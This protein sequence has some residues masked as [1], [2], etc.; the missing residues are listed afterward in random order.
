L[1]VDESSP[2]FLA[3]VR[4][5][6]RARQQATLE[7]MMAQLSGR[8]V[9]LLNYEAAR[10]LA[11]GDPVDRGLQEI[12][13]DAI[14]GS[15]G[16]YHDFTRSFLP[17]RKSDQ[18][19]WAR[20]RTVISDL[21]KMPPILVYQIGQVYFVLDGNHRVS[22]ARQL[23]ATHI[24][25][26]VTEIPTNVPLPPDVRPDELICQL[27]YADFLERTH[28]DELRPHA[29]LTVTAP[30]QYRV[31]EKQ[32]E[33]HHQWLNRQQ[34]GNVPFTEAVEHW[35][36]EVYLPV[37]EVIR[38][39][40]TLR[41]FPGR[42]ETDLY[43]WVLR[44]QAELKEELGWDLGPESVASDLESHFSLRPQQIV[45]RIKEKVVDILTPDPLEAGPP[46]GHWRQEQLAAP[47]ARPPDRLFSEILVPVNG[48][49]TG[50][51]A[52]AEA[53]VVAKREEGR[54]HG[55]YVVTENNRKQR[56]QAQATQSEFEERCRLA[57]VPGD[58]TVAKGNVARQICQHAR[59][60]DLIIASLK[61]PPQAR[62][63]ARL[64]SGFSTLIRR[65]ARPVLAVPG[66]WSP[67]DRPLLAYDGSPK[68][69]E[70]LFVAT[71][72]SGQ[73]QIP[74]VVLTATENGS[75]TTQALARA[76]EYIE[77]RGLQA[78]FVEEQD[79]VVKAIEKTAA[80][81]EINLIIMGGY[82]FRPVFEVVLGSTVDRVLRL[83]QWPVLI[84]R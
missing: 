38:Q 2:A 3:A 82:G 17:R 52:L 24:K 7:T 39:R 18:Q 40:G 27:K 80:A 29:D 70:A 25:A 65:C 15:V 84:C 63:G 79:S 9:E 12:P 26:Y 8:S 59:W 1:T 20:L 34:Q 62:P 5:F 19:R 49:E 56:Q 54:V 35:Y 77:T 44:H 43:V 68:A 11:S 71:Y 37:I 13:L 76:Q 53:V 42:T 58:L 73:W 41:H 31:L 46:P 36:D 21:E 72:L 28:L 10:Q 57:G 67:L 81:H 23:G 60:A 51:R 61:H 50:W 69:D 6:R 33:A 64:S 55:L 16:R 75:E 66:N 74:L 30:G 45:S 83:R 4:D 14:V 22:I 32:I 78:T 48:R 47:V